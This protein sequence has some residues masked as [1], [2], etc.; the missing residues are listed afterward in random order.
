MSYRRI[1]YLE[2]RVHLGDLLFIFQDGGTV[3]YVKYSAEIAD[4]YELLATFEQS[5]KTFR[6]VR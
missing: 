6:I 1:L 2:N 5:V 4:F 3:W